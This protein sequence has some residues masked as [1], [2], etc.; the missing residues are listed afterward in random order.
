M[1]KSI[2]VKID[3]KIFKDTDEISSA[4]KLP[5]NSYIHDALTF[6]NKYNKRQILKEK[7]KRESSLAKQVSM[8]ILAIFE[9]LDD[10][11]EAI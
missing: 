2:S 6:Y 7:L 11:S 8:Q 3:E 10:R 1:M 5:R 4:L 9:Q